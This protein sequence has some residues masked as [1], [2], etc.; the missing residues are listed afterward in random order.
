MTNQLSRRTFLAGTSM[1]SSLLVVSTTS[2]KRPPSDRLNLAVMGIRGRGRDLARGFAGLDA[3]EVT[4]LI[5][6]DSRLFD[7][8]VAEVS[9]RQG[10]TPATL[11]DL[12]RVLDDPSVDGLVV[13][14]PDHWHAP[15]AIMASQAGKHVYVEKPASHTLWEGRRMVDVARAERR[16]I[17][18]GTQ[19]RSAPHYNEA[20]GLLQAG[21]IGEVIQA[22]AWNSQRRPNLAAQRAEPVPDGVDYDLWLG[23]S[24]ERPFHP[25]RFHYT[26]HWFWDY[27]TGDVGNDGI[28]DLDIARWGLGV[29]L[30]ETLSCT[31]LQTKNTRWETPDTVVATFTF[32]ETSKLLVFEQ[33]DWAPYTELGFENGVTF[34]GTEG[35][36]EI[37]RAGYRLY[38]GNELVKDQPARTTN[39][40]HLLDFVD[41]VK[42]IEDRRPH[43]DIEEGHHSASLA[44]LINIAYR[45][46]RHSLRFD[47]KTETILEDPD[48]QALTRRTYR[49]P[50]VIPDQA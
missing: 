2:A 33:R 50:F 10:R 34:Y 9:D 4:H 31:V 11:T 17:Q 27:G 8:V 26:W 32:P 14:A 40:P 24:P 36:I 41:A 35:R 15:A 13:A 20:V 21:R 47:P 39:E 1:A 25:H 3:T 5:D 29:G 6:V 49:A 28:H 12:R 42:S 48:A 43:A 38:L 46:G 44:H 23:P 18:V 7:Q 30:P 45:T 37:G 22:T 19:N 16:V